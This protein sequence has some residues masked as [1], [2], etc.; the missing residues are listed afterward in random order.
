MHAEYTGCICFKSISG[1][2]LSN[3]KLS[4][5]NQPYI[6][7]E[8]RQFDAKDL[9]SLPSFFQGLK[10]TPTFYSFFKVVCHF[11]PKDS[12]SNRC[13]RCWQAIADSHTP[14]SGRNEWCAFPNR[15]NHPVIGDV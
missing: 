4:H 3:N 1:T 13:T 7:H 14:A 10:V 5:D 8:T 12:A 6:T 2:D 9:S 15:T 11:R